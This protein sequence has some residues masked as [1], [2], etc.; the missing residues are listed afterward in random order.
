M[1]L[2]FQFDFKVSRWDAQ[3]FGDFAYNL[4]GAERARDA[5][6]AYTAVL[7]QAPNSSVKESPFTPQIHDDKAYQ[8]GLAFA[9]PGSLGLASGTG[10]FRHAWEFRTYWQHTEQY[11][12]DPN[13]IDSDIFEGRENLEGICVSAAYGLTDNLIG[14]V[15]YG[16]ATRIN[17]QLG[18][19]GSNQDI[20]Q[21]NPINSFDLFQVDMTLKF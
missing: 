18:T 3:L 13:V 11:A 8:I 6:A 14:T 5:A 19:G 10:S 16:H 20:P 9:S 7:A 4:E 21:V 12:L 2:P 15:R 17:K 1:E